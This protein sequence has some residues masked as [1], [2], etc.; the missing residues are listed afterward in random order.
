MQGAAGTRC[1][2]YPVRQRAI[3]AALGRGYRWPSHGQRTASPGPVPANAA[4]AAQTRIGFHPDH[5]C[6][7]T[8]NNPKQQRGVHH[9]PS[10]THLVGRGRAY[11]HPISANQGRP[12]L[13]RVPALRPSPSCHSPP[14]CSYDGHTPVPGDRKVPASS[15]TS[16]AGK[17]PCACLRKRAPI[18]LP[19]YTSARSIGAIFKLGI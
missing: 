13:D 12:H 5:L 15:G 19:A 9:G 3:T 11:R 4:G 2:R 10:D 8:N 16:R 7:T 17:Q 6:P 14:L 18:V 1:L